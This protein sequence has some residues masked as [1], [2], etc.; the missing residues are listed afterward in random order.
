MELDVRKRDEGMHGY[1]PVSLTADSQ[2]I[3]LG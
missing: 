2:Y 1:V 3:I